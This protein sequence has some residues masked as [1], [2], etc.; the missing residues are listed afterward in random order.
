[1]SIELAREGYHVLGIDISGK[2]IGEAQEVLATNPFTE[3][4][5]S[6]DYRQ[7]GLHEVEGTYDVVL[8]SVSL[9]HMTDLE[10]AVRRA[11]E[12]LKPG[13]RLLCY[14]PCHER[15]TKADAAQVALIR[16]LL[17]L[18]GRWYDPAD[19][20]P[21]LDDEAGIASL[22]EDIHVEYVEER[23]KHE[24][25]QSPHDNESTGEEMLAALR[26][27]F[28]ELETRPGHSFIYRLLGGIRGTDQEIHDLAEFISA[29][30]RYA[31]AAGSMN[32]NGFYFIGGKE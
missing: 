29:Y 5:G 7:M 16:G 1:M 31:V 25:G 27:H 15:W 21:Q 2:C 12:L 6:L 18:T 30:D 20:R 23:D 13:G 17:A 10:G 24:G 32:P 28:R 9:H 3:T 26:R 22:V 11:K 19:I 8:F 14:E 4:F